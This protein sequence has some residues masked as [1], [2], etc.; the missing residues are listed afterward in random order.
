MV[1][2]KQFFMLLLGP[3][4]PRWRPF[5]KLLPQK[6]RTSVAPVSPRSRDVLSAERRESPVEVRDAPE[7]DL[8]SSSVF[9]TAGN[10]GRTSDCCPF[11]SQ[12]KS[13]VTPSGN[14]GVTE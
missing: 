9:D 12:A 11:R 7:T 4:M 1:R 3:G 5:P 13:V 6:M 10:P 8:V 14:P 2:L